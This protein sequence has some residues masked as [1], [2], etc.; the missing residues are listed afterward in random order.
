MR[1]TGILLILFSLLL[2]GCG[3]TD[4]AGS[5]T[6][7]ASNPR[8]LTIDASGGE[9][10]KLQ[11]EIADNDAE[12]QRGLMERTALGSNRGM[13]FVFEDEQTLSFWMKNTLIPLSV[14]YLDSEGR[15]IDIQDM[16]PLDE[17]PHPSA[18]PAQYA[19]EVNQGFFEERGVKV[20]DKAKLPVKEPAA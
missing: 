9:T 5:G 13:L 19:L 1:Y 17:T 7:A 2:A 16:Q 15:I 18:E 12:R 11:V 3:G 14:A 20:G 6:T 10:V 4:N 8:P